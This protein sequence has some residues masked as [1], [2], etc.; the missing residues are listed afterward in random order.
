M[1][2]VEYLQSFTFVISHKSGVTNRVANALS[3]RFSLLTKMNVEVLGF[4][5]MKELYDDD[6][7][8]YEV[9]RECRA[10][11]L[12][13]HM[14][15]YDEYFIQEGMLFKGI[16]LCIPRSSMRVNLINDKHYRGLARHYG[17]Y[18]TLIFLKDKYYW[19]Q[20][21]REVQK[22][23]RSCRICQVIKG[24]GQITRLYT[25]ISIS[26]KPWSDISMDF[27][28]GLPKTTIGYDSIFCCFG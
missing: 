15:K 26:K 24:V 14:S 3:K 13:N 6:P 10:P 20:M 25:P 5:E 2:W 11:N 19:P 28:L 16:Q 9:W 18:K 21:Y 27:V 7:N 22:F 23:V 8:F 17:I 4:D 12:T 1:K